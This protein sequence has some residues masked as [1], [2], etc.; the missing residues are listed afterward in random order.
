MI[1]IF[2]LLMTCG[3]CTGLWWVVQVNIHLTER[4]NALEKNVNAFYSTME[5]VNVEMEKRARLMEKIAE[6]LESRVFPKDYSS[7]S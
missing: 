2:L 6:D 5:V 3:A 1:D 4:V 7:Q